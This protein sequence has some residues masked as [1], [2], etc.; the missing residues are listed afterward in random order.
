MG[1]EME[2]LEPR[3]AACSDC[4][5]SAPYRTFAHHP[6]PLA[7]QVISSAGFVYRGVGIGPS[8]T[9]L[10][11]EVTNREQTMNAVAEI[12]ALWLK[13]GL[14]LVRS[15]GPYGDRDPAAGRHPDRPAALAFAAGRVHDPCSSCATD[16][17]DLC[18]D[19]AHATR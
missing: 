16:R 12:V 3:G 9:S 8:R 11:Q 19:L 4:R 10:R 7:T 13:R 5:G 1:A 6:A 14:A 17:R 15:V 18:N 2:V